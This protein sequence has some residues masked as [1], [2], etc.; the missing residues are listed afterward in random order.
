MSL[1]CLKSKTGDKP[2]IYLFPPKS[3]EEM[4]VAV[5]LALVPQWKFFA[6]YPVIP[7]KSQAPSGHGE[8]LTWSV[9]INEDQTLTEKTT[10]LTVSY[11]YWEAETQAV[12]P[13]PPGS[14]VP[15]DEMVQHFDPITSDV[16]DDDG[17]SVL[18]PLAELTPYLDA[19]LKSLGLHTEART[20]FIT[21]WLPSFNKHTYIALRFVPQAAYA[22]AASLNHF[23]MLFRGVEE[24][25]LWL[26]AIARVPE[27]LEKWKDVIGCGPA[28]VLADDDLFRVLEWGGMEVKKWHTI[29][30]THTD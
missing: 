13:T 22:R 10:G 25:D 23:F 27:S 9:H 5:D 19:A 11:L 8:N 18:L 26:N 14:P 2:V 12:L 6:I 17:V 4:D 30:D 7:T 29:Q 3:S 24:P 21:Y 28:D 20:S 1:S 15:G 16:S